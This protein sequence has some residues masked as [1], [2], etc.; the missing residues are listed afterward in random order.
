MTTGLSGPPTVP[1]FMLVADAA[2]VIEGS[3]D[4]EVGEENRPIINAEVGDDAALV[5]V[6]AKLAGH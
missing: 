2:D 6:N 4:P 5:D 3:G 1:T